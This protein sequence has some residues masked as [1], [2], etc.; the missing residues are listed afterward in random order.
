LPKEALPAPLGYYPGPVLP[1]RIVANVLRVA[2]F[3]ISDPMKLLILVESGDAAWNRGPVRIHQVLSDP[4]LSEPLTA[5][6]S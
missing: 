1:G 6:I 4:E 3:Q 5:R 2:A